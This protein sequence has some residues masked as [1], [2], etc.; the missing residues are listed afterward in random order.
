MRYVQSYVAFVYSYRSYENTYH[1]LVTY[2]PEVS[3]VWMEFNAKSVDALRKCSSCGDHS[4][5]KQ[6]DVEIHCYTTLLHLPSRW[7]IICVPRLH[8]YISLKF[9]GSRLI[10]NFKVLRIDALGSASTLA[11]KDFCQL[12]SLLKLRFYDDLVLGS[13]DPIESWPR[14]RII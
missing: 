14:Q 7:H 13:K 3:N 11:K 9:L 2:M 6:D 5:K 10:A 12:I 4:L 8:L 1:T